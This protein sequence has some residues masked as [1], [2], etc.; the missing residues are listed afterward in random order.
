MSI[1]CER[2]HRLFNELEMHSFPF[3]E[4]KV[5]LI[6]HRLQADAFSGRVE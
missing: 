1:E 4:S 5:S 6:H 2:V 3:D